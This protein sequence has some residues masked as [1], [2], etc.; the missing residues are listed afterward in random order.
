MN[1]ELSENLLNGRWQWILNVKRY[2]N[3]HTIDPISVADHSWLVAMLSMMIFDSIGFYDGSIND[4]L[5]NIMRGELLTRA[6]LHDVEESLTGDIPLESETRKAMKYAKGLVSDDIMKAIFPSDIADKYS[7]HHMFAKYNQTTEG[8][9]VKYADMLSAL[10]E[11]LREKKL[12]NT[13]FDDIIERAMG[14]LRDMF[15]DVDC[16]NRTLLIKTI[17]YLNDLTKDIINYIAIT[18]SIRTKNMV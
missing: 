1:N 11:A 4:D 6:I 8:C 10:I 15:I 5:V 7:A 16:G 14:F 2:Q 13:N 18:Y 9:I 12:G 3:R 17:N